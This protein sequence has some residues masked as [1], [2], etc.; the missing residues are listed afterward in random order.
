MTTGGADR[1]MVHLRETYALALPF[2]NVM[3]ADVLHSRPP[4]KDHGSGL[5]SANAKVVQ[6][7]VDR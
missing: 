7:V 2:F 3:R 4:S 5:A 6:L 1:R